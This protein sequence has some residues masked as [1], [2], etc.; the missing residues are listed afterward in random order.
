V[1]LSQFLSVHLAHHFLMNWE[2]KII[3]AFS[4]E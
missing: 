3:K 2:H 4:R 1:F